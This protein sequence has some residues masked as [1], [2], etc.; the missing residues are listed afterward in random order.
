MGA[1]DFL[2][3]HHIVAGLY[4]VADAFAGGVDTDV[5][6][7]KNYRRATLVVMTG[8]VEDTGTSNLVTIKACTDAAKTNAT[9]MAYV[10]RFCASS[11]TVDTWEALAT[12]AAAG[13]N[14]ADRADAGVDNTIWVAEVTADGVGAA[15][16]DANFVYATIAETAN[17]TLT[18]C[19]FWI[20]S[21][22]RYPQSIPLTAIA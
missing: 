5:V 4:P 16:A 13:Y 14:F 7:L 2:Y 11:T 20:L 19:A 9:T 10:R 6:S 1:K 18:A 15:F 3:D 21:E 17:K 12:V 8:V 22:P